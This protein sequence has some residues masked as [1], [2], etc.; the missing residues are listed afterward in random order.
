MRILGITASSIDP[1]FA[2]ESIATQAITSNT[3]TVTFGSIPSTYSSLQ[4]RILSRSTRSA[5]ANLNIQVNS[6]TGTVYTRHELSGDGATVSASGSAAGGV[7]TA[8]IARSTGTDSASDVFGVSI[9]DIHDYAS[10][11][12]NKT[13]RSFYGIDN[14]SAAPAGV[15]GLRSVLY[16]GTDAITSL[17][18]SSA[19]STNFVSGSLFALYGIKGA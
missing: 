13:I 1:S 7:T 12:K 4:L 19:S 3:L 16:I 15:I 2:F 10:T 5:M 6:A 8:S 17:T 9:I 11:T 18:L 14:N